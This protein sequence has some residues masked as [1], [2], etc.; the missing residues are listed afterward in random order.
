[1]S[2]AGDDDELD[3]QKAAAVETAIAAPDTVADFDLASYHAQLAR[4][5]APT[6][7]CSIAGTCLG[8]SPVLA[9][10]LRKVLRLKDP[11]GLIL[12]D[13]THSAVHIR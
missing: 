7:R 1:M 4:D 12:H 11:A 2:A 3:D 13:A 6:V 8:S 9:V 10:R 5:N